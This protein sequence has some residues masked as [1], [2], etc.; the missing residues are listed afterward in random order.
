MNR[1][2]CGRKQE[3]FNLR[4]P[5]FSWSDRGKDKISVRRGGCHEVLSTQP[6]HLVNILHS[7]FTGS[8]Y[9]SEDMSSSY[10]SLK[11]GDRCSQP[12]RI[13][14]KIHT[15]FLCYNIHCTVPYFGF[16]TPYADVSV[17]FEHKYC[18][19]GSVSY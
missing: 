12:Y 1:R 3:W 18:K 16:C 19:H 5:A 13:T 17:I 15:T 14:G 9:F 6:Q 7:S 4:F 2:V 11:V 10:S 8:V